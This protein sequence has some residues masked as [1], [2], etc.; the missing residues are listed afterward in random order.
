MFIAYTDA[1]LKDDKAG[2]GYAI[3]KNAKLIYSCRREVPVAT[4]N[5]LEC[6]S[7]I[8]LLR[9]INE[10]ELKNV[11]IFTDNKNVVDQVHLE[12]ASDIYIDQILYELSINP[13]LE[14]KWIDRKFNK[15]AHQLSRE[16]MNGYGNEEYDEPI[17][18]FKAKKEKYELKMVVKHRKYMILKC[19]VCKE[20]KPASEFPRYKTD[21]KK[22][23]CKQ[24]QNKIHYFESQLVKIKYT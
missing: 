8:E 3:Y 14:I 11:T 19:P 23:K 12:K 18:N 1:S 15:K 9:Y 16:A 5:V 13:T 17:N 4:I 6:L 21:N 24:C 20:Y 2:I 22:R 7:L 10:M